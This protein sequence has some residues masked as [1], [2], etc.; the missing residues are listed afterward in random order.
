MPAV[1]EVYRQCEDFLALGPVATASLEMVQA[2]RDLSRREGGRFCGIFCPSQGGELVGILD[3]TLASPDH[4]GVLYIELLMIGQP[5]RGRGVGAAVVDWLL[6]Q[7]ADGV[8]CVQAG[9]QANNPGAIRFWQR[10]GFAITGPAEIQ[11]DTT[12]A[13]PLERP[14]TG[15]VDN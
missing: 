1:L 10:M 12:V 3:Y 6:E 11:P 5:Q 2:D 14:A 8:R 7:H 4:P 13:Y 15:P 9:V